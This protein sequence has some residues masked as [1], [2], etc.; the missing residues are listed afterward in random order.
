[1][2][3]R[4]EVRWNRSTGQPGYLLDTRTG[5]IHALNASAAVLLDALN[6]GAE[7][8]TLEQSLRA[9]FDVGELAARDDVAAFTGLLLENDLVEH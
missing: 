6:A 8:T 2:K 7:A 1:M 9:H 4:S 3:L 5:S